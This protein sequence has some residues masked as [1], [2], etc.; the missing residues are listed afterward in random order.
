MCDYFG[1][2]GFRGRS[3]KVTSVKEAGF[4]GA[5][6]GLGLG[7]EFSGSI[8]RNTAICDVPVQSGV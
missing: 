5:Y 1:G 7:P 2:R 6:A 4:I 3:T 8:E